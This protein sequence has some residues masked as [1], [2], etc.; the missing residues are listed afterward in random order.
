MGKHVGRRRCAPG[1]DQKGAARLCAEADNLRVWH[2]LNP[3]WSLEVEDGAHVRE[4]RPQGDTARVPKEQR[5]KRVIPAAVKRT[6][7]ARDGFRCRFCGIPVVAAESRK[8]VHRLYPESVPWH[9]SEVRRQHAGFAVMWL[10]YDHVVPLS[11]GGRTA[12]SNLVIT[13]ALCNFAKWNNTLKQLHLEDPR[14]R[15]PQKMV[16]YDGLERLGKA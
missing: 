2:W 8:I 3:A 16:G 4:V 14:D 12:E 15:A 9:S 5:D 11:H 6:V 1:G 13:C 10:Q 7:L